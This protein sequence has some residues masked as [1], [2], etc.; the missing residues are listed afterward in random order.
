VLHWLRQNAERGDMGESSATI[1]ATALRQLSEQVAPS[2]PQ[3]ARFVAQNI[4]QLVRRWSTKNPGTSAKSASAYETRARSTINEYL[5]WEAAPEKYVYGE[6]PAKKD[7]GGKPVKKKAAKSEASPPAAAPPPAPAPPAPT[8]A[9][10]PMSELRLGKGREPFRFILPTDGLTLAD[11][12]RIAYHLITTCD[13][14]DPMTM[15]PLQ[16]M[17]SAIE[18]AET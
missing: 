9:Q 2:E 13:D 14:F 6:R 3:S 8:S 1:R 4:K 15:T 16:V 17:S 7:Q 12:R 18:R 5:R 10:S 11:A